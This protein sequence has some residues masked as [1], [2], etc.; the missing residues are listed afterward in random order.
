VSG[1][2]EAPDPILALRDLSRQLNADLHFYRVGDRQALSIRVV[3]DDQVTDLAKL[4][5]APAPNLRFHDGHEWT[6][7]LH[8]VHGVSV[9]ISSEHRV[10]CGRCR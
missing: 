3:D 9:S 6:E 10:R 1:Y 7:S 4:L 5:G 2:T 8:T